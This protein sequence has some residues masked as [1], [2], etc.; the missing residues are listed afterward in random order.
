MTHFINVLQNALAYGRRRILKNP[1]PIWMYTCL[2]WAVSAFSLVFLKVR[3]SLFLKHLFLFTFYNLLFIWNT[4][5]TI[6]KMVLWI[7]ATLDSELLFP[8]FLGIIS[9]AIVYYP[10]LPKGLRR[11]HHLK[12]SC[13]TFERSHTSITENTIRRKFDVQYIEQHN[14]DLFDVLYIQRNLTSNT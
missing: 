2:L 9:D 14:A 3:A 12:L 10:D 11:E 1:S 13:G 5:C 7:N 8:L 4:K 6:G